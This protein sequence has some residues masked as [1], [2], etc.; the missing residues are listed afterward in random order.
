ML[1]NLII[2]HNKATKLSFLSLVDQLV[3]V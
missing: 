1:G 3:W 2:F